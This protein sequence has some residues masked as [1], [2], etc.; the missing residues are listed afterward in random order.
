MTCEVVFNVQDS[1]QPD[2]I[3]WFDMSKNSFQLS[4]N[5]KLLTANLVN[6]TNTFQ[7]TEF[8]KN[9]FKSPS[10]YHC[11]TVVDNLPVLCAKS[12]LANNESLSIIETTTVTSIFTKD[13]QTSTIAIETS[14]DNLETTKHIQNTNVTRI[15]TNAIT[16]ASTQTKMTTLTTLTTNPIEYL[17]IETDD[18]DSQEKVILKTLKETYV[19]MLTKTRRIKI[20]CRKLSF[21][22][23]SLIVSLNGISSIASKCNSFSFGSP[24]EDYFCLSKT[25]DYDL[26][27]IPEI[28]GDFFNIICSIAQNEAFV[29]KAK[30]NKLCM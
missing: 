4:S 27:N 3:Q 18:F 26:T 2:E 29:A 28:P 6:V 25:F 5:R 14:T 22:E 16:D 11:C 19:S 13:H 12:Y 1:S 30:L 9:L 17:G 10:I 23:G 7:L 8:N 24:I 21:R 15:T 20:T